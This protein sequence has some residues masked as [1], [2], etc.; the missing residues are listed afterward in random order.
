MAR[1]PDD[2]RQFMQA[3]NV[4]EDEVWP[5]PGGKAYAVK[6]KAL[7]R[8]AAEKGIAFDPPQIIE[9]NGPEKCAALCV[10]GRSNG[11]PSTSMTHTAG[12]CPSL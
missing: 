5:V 7:E 3:H 6:H 1:L 10:T 8:I 2:I 11:R 12:P 9:A 4:R